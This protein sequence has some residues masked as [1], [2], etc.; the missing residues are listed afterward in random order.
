M[1]IADSYMQAKKYES[2]PVHKNIEGKGN[3]VQ[4]T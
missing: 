2:A 3:T 1:Q 4:Q